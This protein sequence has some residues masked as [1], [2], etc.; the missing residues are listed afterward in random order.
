MIQIIRVSPPIAFEEILK[1]I[2]L[3]TF[4]SDERR[5]WD[6]LMELTK[7]PHFNLYC[8]NYKNEP[9]G[10]ITVW[11]WQELAFIEHFAVSRS[12]QGKGIGSKVINL[13]VQDL[14]SAIILETEEANTESAIRRIN[15]Y[16][17]LGFY[18]CQEEYYQPPYAKDKEAVKMLLMSY[19]DRITHSE[20]IDIRAKLYKEVYKRNIIEFP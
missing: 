8:I 15:F 2:Y 17:R 12:L 5:D 14:T 6:E 19:P 9:A 4:P 16:T 18:I 20:F 10:L 13:V 3:T 11:K 1:N 7:L